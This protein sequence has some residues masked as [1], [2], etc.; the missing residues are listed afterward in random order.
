MLYTWFSIEFATQ[1]TQIVPSDY[2]Y[3]VKQVQA[4]MQKY[5]SKAITVLPIPRV[6]LLCN[7]NISLTDQKILE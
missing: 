4:N 1:G 7:I 6:M 2:I 5:G 3:I